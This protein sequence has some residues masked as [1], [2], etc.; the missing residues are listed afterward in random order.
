[1]AVQERGVLGKYSDFASICSDFAGS[2]DCFQSVSF[3]PLC[4]KRELSDMSKHPV[5]ADRPPR[6]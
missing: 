3:E 2:I 4:Y 6:P 5:D 1:M